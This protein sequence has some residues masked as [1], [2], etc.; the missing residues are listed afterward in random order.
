MRTAM[1]SPMTSNSVHANQR[2]F[3]RS[4]TSLVWWHAVS[5][6]DPLVNVKR[7]PMVNRT[8]G[9]SRLRVHGNHGMVSSR[10]CSAS[11]VTGRLAA[12]RRLRFQHLDC[13]DHWTP[14]APVACILSRVGR[15]SGADL[16]ATDDRRS[17]CRRTECNPSAG[18][19]CDCATIGGSPR[20]EASLMY[21]R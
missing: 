5:T 12:R 3:T 10:S 2:W 16:P 18:T 17:G 19:G 13:G 6:M 14:R 11:A 8:T 7:S 9:S 4:G 15:T 21:S 1:R 20:S